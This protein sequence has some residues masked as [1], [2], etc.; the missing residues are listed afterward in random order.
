MHGPSRVRVLLVGVLIALFALSGVL[1]ATVAASGLP[2]QTR[3]QSLLAQDV[4]LIGDDGLIDLDVDADVDVSVGNPNDEPLVDVNA[5]ADLTATETPTVQV[6]VP[7]TLDTTTSQDDAPVVAATID[8]N[9]GITVSQTDEDTSLVEAE[10]TVD[11]GVTVDD[12]SSDAPLVGADIDAG[13]DV[14][15]GDSSDGSLVE[16]DA[17][18]TTDVTVGDTGQDD[19]SLVDVDAN[20]D[21][22]VTVG[23]VETP[24]VAVDA[25]TTVDANV[26][27]DP[28]A[29]A[30]LID[31]D[32]DALINVAIGGNGDENE[33]QA[34]AP[35]ETATDDETNGSLVDADVDACVGVAV[36]GAT[37]GCAIPT[38][39]ASANDDDSLVDV[40][41]DA[42]V[43]VAILGAADDCVEAA[44]T[45]T[46]SETVVPTETV[47][48]E[49]NGTET[50]E[51]TVPATVAPT[52]TVTTEPTVP[53]TTETPDPSNVDVDVCV[54]LFGAGLLDANGNVTVSSLPALLSAVLGSGLTIDADVLAQVFGGGCAAEG[55]AP[56][57]TVPATTETP[58]ATA[59]TTETV[60]AGTETPGATVTTETTST[61]A[62]DVDVC[63]ALLG[64]NLLDVDGN[65]T[66]SSLPDLIA[67]VLGSGLTIDADV[68]AL[69]FSGGCAAQIPTATA[70]TP[71]GT[72]TPGATVTT[73]TE[74]TGTETPAAT[75]TTESTTTPTVDI[76]V[77]ADL[78]GANLIDA[79]GNVTVASLPDL[80]A[81]VLGSGLSIDADVLAQ[82]LGGG[83]AAQV[84]TAT[85]TVPTGTETPGTTATTPVE[86]TGT[87]TTEPTST[88]T[89]SPTG[90]PTVDID[91][92]VALF[93]AGL[94]DA[95][96]N[97]TLGSLPALVTAVLNAGLTIDA[98]VLALVFS[99]GCAATPTA[100]TTVPSGTETPGAT[101]TAT[102]TTPSGTETPTT[103]V[104][105]EPTSTP[106]VDVDV[107]VALFSNGLL[108]LDGNVTVSSLPDLIAAVLGSGLDIDAD[109]LAQVFAGGCA[110]AIPTA[111]T[112]FPAGT[113]TPT[114]TVTTTTEPTGTVTTEPTSSATA[115]TTATTEPTGTPT[116]DVDVCVALFGANL[117]DANGNVT[118]S[119]LPD[120]IAAVLGSGLSIDADVLAQVFA[121]GCAAQV[122]TTT[123]TSTVPTGTETPRATVSATTTATVPGGSETPVGTETPSATVTE[124][125]TST[126]PTGTETPSATTTPSMTVT[127]EPTQPTATATSEPSPTTTATSVPATSLIVYV[128]TS[129]G[130]DIPVG[131]NW[132]L[133]QVAPIRSMTG[134]EAFFAA[135]V[136]PGQGGTFATAMPS[137][138]Q[139]PIANPV[140]LGTYSLSITADGYQ[141]SVTS[142]DH[143]IENGVTVVTVELMAIQAP[144]ATTTAVPTN[145]ATPETPSGTETP[146]VPPTAPGNGNDSGASGGQQSPA[147]PVAD[148][149]PV[150]GSGTPS[151]S[152]PT[153]MLVAL[154]GALAVLAA[155]TAFMVRRTPDQIVTPGDGITRLASRRISDTR[156]R[157]T[158]P[159]P[160]AV[161][162]QTNARRQRPRGHHWR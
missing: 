154:L 69:V 136:A 39:E 62:V 38:T 159:R 126:V 133:S 123:A 117:I 44:A 65:V 73:T 7:E 37:E 59:T 22:D 87:V 121:G 155:L 11:T 63:A 2:N 156:R 137:G 55:P 131:T 153:T 67:A 149:L 142:I 15:V 41:A 107:C 99:G 74:P 143:L 80:I 97:V 29:N 92:C 119:S 52:N 102:A 9:V 53:A 60:P 112:T 3:S 5:D 128:I 70:T 30:P 26:E 42:C 152:N 93:G 34:P 32:A 129:D 33:D 135:Q 76:D 148:T 124:T 113:E 1:Q 130:A 56:T 150:T 19:T 115:T 43:D 106:T 77:C 49:P 104:T 157:N 85:T 103:T 12:P 89:T 71:A 120:L 83:C 151:T 116:V 36:L 110:A 90:T 122:P 68:L 141:P 6:D 162:R 140:E 31:V 20:A 101:V 161:G 127:T 61:P 111:T 45:E 146:A 108:D 125:A 17:T 28:L 72:E 138:S 94:L 98:D 139:L 95:S 134:Q 96:G 51:P 47:T 50:V 91:V 66:A 40:D 100:T 35:T 16:A 79:N 145:T 48:P 64:A 118:V 82:V 8:A 144:T 10:A 58:G 88:A 18:T 105:S 14:T 21:A 109:V 158:A 23:D 78:L 46:P 54:A 81:A 27:T 114:I 24:V 132:L 75:G 86:P 84:P 160:A 4:P 13:A 57:T 25:E 147:A